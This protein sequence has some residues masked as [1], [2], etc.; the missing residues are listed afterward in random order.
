[1]RRRGRTLLSS[2][3]R[4]KTAW[5]SELSSPSHCCCVDLQLVPMRLLLLTAWLTACTSFP[6]CDSNSLHFRESTQH[7][8]GGSRST[9]PLADLQANSMVQL[10]STPTSEWRYTT[11]GILERNRNTQSPE[12]TALMLASPV[13]DRLSNIVPLIL[14]R[15]GLSFT[16]ER[17]RD[18]H[19]LSVMVGI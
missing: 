8:H 7:D 15:L 17:V 5:K 16:C 9:L 1:M 11:D 2:W 10:S 6:L 13:R 4:V 18:A 19:S 14:L 12:I 3:T